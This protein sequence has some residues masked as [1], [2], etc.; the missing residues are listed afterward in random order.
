MVLLIYSSILCCFPVASEAVLA[1][2]GDSLDMMGNAFLF[3]ATGCQVARDVRVTLQAIFCL[4]KADTGNKN[5]RHCGKADNPRPESVVVH[6]CPSKS[7]SVES[8]IST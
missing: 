2:N 8:L 3:S 5:K 6:G 7:K 4:C 1:G